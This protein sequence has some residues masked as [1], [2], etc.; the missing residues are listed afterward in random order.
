VGVFVAVFVLVGS[1]VAVLVGVFVGSFVAVGTG[2]GATNVTAGFC[3]IVTPPAT[4]VKVT[5]FATVDFAVK[6]ATPF[7]P[8]VAEV[9]EITTFPEGLALIRTVIEL[10]ALPL[11]FRAVT[12]MVVVAVPFAVTVNGLAETLDLVA[13]TFDA[14][15]TLVVGTMLLTNTKSTTT[16]MPKNLL[17]FMWLKPFWIKSN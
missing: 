1:T 15:R 5:T 6:M 4:A 8:V 2:V 9:G 17:D 10:N 12:V 3:W 14:A 11:L 16:R 13:L 7:V